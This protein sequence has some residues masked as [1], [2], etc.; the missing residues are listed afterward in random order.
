[1]CLI[2]V[3]MGISGSELGRVC[4]LLGVRVLVVWVS[5]VREV[6]SVNVS[7]DSEV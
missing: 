4:G 2:L 5:G 1:M 7:S 6:V 3:G